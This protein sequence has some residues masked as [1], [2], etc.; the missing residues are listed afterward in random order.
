MADEPKRE[1][2]RLGFASLPLPR[3]DERSQR[4]HVHGR[5]RQITEIWIEL[6]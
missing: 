4:A 2:D 5:K 1:I 3:L 6:F